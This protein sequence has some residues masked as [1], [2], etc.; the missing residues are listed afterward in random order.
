MN[1]P[2]SRAYDNYEAPS[3]V[4]GDFVGCEFKV[5]NRHVL[6]ASCGTGNNALYFA[7]HGY[8]VLGIDDQQSKVAEARMR[9]AEARQSGASLNCGFTENDLDTIHELDLGVYGVVTA[10]KVL[11]ARTGPDVAL[12]Y[13]RFL[14]DC[15]A[16]GGYHVMSE[17]LYWSSYDDSIEA[18]RQL[19]RHN[20]YRNFYLRSG[21]RIT[22]YHEEGPLTAKDGRVIPPQVRLIAQKR[23]QDFLERFMRLGLRPSTLWGG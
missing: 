6:D 13:L 3:R 1:T 17:Q 21:W 9:L 11:H 4:V 22:K 19:I 7:R 10:N 2:E 8:N 20:E 14:Q 15:T 16:P 23:R 18:R 5:P 12:Q